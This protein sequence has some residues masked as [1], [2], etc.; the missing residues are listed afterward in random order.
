MDGQMCAQQG[1][2][3]LIN[4]I[5][6]PCF[7]KLVSNYNEGKKKKKSR[8]RKRGEGEGCRQ[9][10]ESGGGDGGGVTFLSCVVPQLGSHRVRLE[11][12]SP[13]YL[14][15]RGAPAPPPPSPACPLSPSVLSLQL[16]IVQSPSAFMKCGLAAR[17]EGGQGGLKLNSSPPSV[18]KDLHP[19]SLSP[20]TRPNPR[21]SGAQPK[22]N[23]SYPAQ[24]TLTKNQFPPLRNLFHGGRNITAHHGL[25]LWTTTEG[26]RISPLNN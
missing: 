10:P 16:W 2:F 9:E 1:D 17:I 4:L 19:V 15:Q 14:G 7:F 11:P 23:H 3:T 24:W 21:R 13:Q 26:C 8:R 6:K 25:R 18:H 12:N 20:Q 22:K 5:M